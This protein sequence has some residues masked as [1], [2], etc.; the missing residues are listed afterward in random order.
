M[1]LMVSSSSHRFYFC[2]FVGLCLCG[3][4][5]WADPPSVSYTF[6]AGGQRGATVDVRIGGHYL[7]DKSPW[8]MS[9]S[10]VTASAE[11]VRTKRI[12]FEGPLIKQPASQASENYPQDYF[13]KVEIAADAPLGGRSWRTWNAQGVTPGMRFVVG[14]LPEV[15][16]QE[17]DGQP[18]PTQVTLPVTINGRIFPREDVDIWTFEAAAGQSVT[19]S[20]EAT[21]LAAPLAPNEQSNRLE[22]QLEIRD[23]QGRPVAVTA[24]ALRSDPELRFTTPAAGTYQ[25]RIWDSKYGGLQHFV[26]RLTV[27]AGPWVDAVYPLG[28]KRGAEAEVEVAGQGIPG[29]R[30]KVRWP[31]A[32]PGIV[33]YSFE[34]AGQPLNQIVCD[35]DDLPEVL[36]PAGGNLPALAVPGIANGRIEQP[37]DA[38][39]WPFTAVKGT[40]LKIE[41]RAARLGSPL[42]AVLVIKDSQ[43]K[44][45]TQADDLPGGAPDCELT[46]TPPAD[47]AYTAEVRDRF[48][49]RGGP[50]FAYR[51]RIS[52]PVPDFALSFAADALSVVIGGEQ[53][54]PITI[55]RRGGFN[56]PVKLAV[57][58]LPAGATCAELDVPANQNK[59]EL[60]VKVAKD[61][62]VQLAKILVVGH[63]A[64]NDQQVERRAAYSSMTVESATDHINMECTLATPFK[65]KSQYEFR[66]IARGGTLKKSYQIERNGFDGPLQVCLADRQGRHLQGIS[67]PTITVPAGANEFDYT[68]TLPPWMELGRTSRTN[69][70]MVGEVADAVGKKHQVSFSTVEQNEQLIALVSPAP[71]RLSV[72][73]SAVSCQAGSQLV[74][75]VHLHRQV[76]LS[77][78]CK[79]EL[80]V[81]EHIHD[82]TAEAVTV[83]AAGET[84]ELKINLGENPGPLNMPLT[85]RGQTERDGGP[86][87]AEVNLELLLKPRK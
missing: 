86:I 26:Y 30:L 83:A 46:F 53:K 14:S 59:G 61:A 73:R 22:A 62:P 68:V 6:P 1:S 82:I 55:D 58:G 74:V 63:A 39:A 21:S 42:D 27:T 84:A 40:P 45:L 34:A 72:D 24:N 19:C 54:L 38:D 80:M 16:E 31:G 67:G 43:G 52:Q 64:M 5:L 35:V 8:E 51:L 36:E 3:S 79:L 65:F 81:P 44:E 18:I 28:G 4:Y 69:L 32:E 13:G 10:G 23:P 77:A 12:W 70:M 2:L 71:L 47:G 50:T 66:Y 76:G 75:P 48:A 17:T 11:I 33:R 37:G 41:V 85:I 57:T 78:A 29:N 7:Y 49:S 15:V 56:A 25:V 87:V 60:V 9:G 20:V